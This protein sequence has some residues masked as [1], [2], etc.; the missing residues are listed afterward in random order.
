MFDLITYSSSSSN[1]EQYDKAE[2]LLKNIDPEKVNWLNVKDLSNKEEI[3]ILCNETCMHPLIM[4]DILDLGQRPQSEDHEDYIFFSINMLKSINESGLV[5]KEH[6]SFILSRNL[7]MSIQEVEG[8]LFNPIRERI[9]TGKG[10]VR[11]LNADYLMYLLIDTITDQYYLILDEIRSR[12]MKT[13]EEMLE[14][15]SDVQISTIIRFKKTLNFIRKSI[16]PLRDSIDKLLKNDNELIQRVSKLYLGNVRSTIIHMISEIEILSDT[17]RG[18]LDL[19]QVKLSNGMNSVMKILTIIAT[20]FIPLTFVAGVYGMNFKFMPELHWKWAYPAVLGVMV[21]IVLV[22][23][24]F[25]KKR[26]WF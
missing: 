9:I 2:D 15:R 22:M 16:Y 20:I 11:N 6:V 4:D 17:V 13:E 19:Y 12:I 18:L 3:S 14:D 10:K 25:M 5:D 26:K 23:I 1:R 7:L 24:L 21:I 8:D